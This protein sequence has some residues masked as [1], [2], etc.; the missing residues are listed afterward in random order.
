MQLTWKQQRQFW[1]DLIVLLLGISSLSIATL[2]LKGL[3]AQEYYTALVFIVLVLL[4]SSQA[5]A[6]AGLTTAAC[7]VFYL[8][9]FFV[10]PY[11]NLNVESVTGVLVIGVFLI[12]ATITSQ[13]AARARRQT[14]EALANQRQTLVLNELN[15][16]VLSEA[17]ADTI[18]QRV[19]EQL[20]SSLAA[21]A[22][23]LYLPQ[24]ENNNLLEVSAIFDQTQLF[25]FKL[26]AHIQ[27]VREAF[28]IKSLTGYQLDTCRV[29]C[30]PLLR[31][32]AVLGVV[33]VLLKLDKPYPTYSGLSPE[34]IRWFSIV[35]NQA[36]LTIQHAY[37]IEQSAH[38]A[39]LKE[40]DELKS[41]L[42]ALVSHELR[43]PLTAIKTA[44]AGL[45]DVGVQL[46]PHEQTEYF[47]VIDQES[48]RLIRLISNMLDL[49]SLESGTFKLEKNLY[50]LPEIVTNAIERIKHTPILVSHPL[51]THFEETLP[52]LPVDYLQIEQVLT[53][54][55]ENAA[56]YSPEGMP[57]SV[58]V[59]QA[60]LSVSRFNQSED[61]SEDQSEAKGLLV[62][63][64]DQGVGI[65]VS[66]L[67]KV[68]DKFYR[69]GLRPS[70]ES[71]INRSGS[72]L[73]LALCKGVVEAHGGRIWVSARTH[74]GSI[75]SFW[76]PL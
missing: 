20:A 40:A 17:S 34:A 65:P 3:S 46:E 55:L 10:P 28:S 15:V 1:H 24:P 6:W 59:S 61:Q 27:S 7:G 12:V 66:D 9:F 64:I 22:T 42:L 68:F 44:V 11:Y 53:N 67:D 5:N 31:Q 75:F 60:P 13:I 35:A 47:E 49:T 39:S 50:Y 69:V 32:E 43:T 51:H 73:G 38:L 21:L 33:C 74:G 29:V 4:V 25:D 72:G 71:T 36:A 23:T 26:E 19:V 76:L 18:L 62:A 58:E 8:D 2:I 16:A 37:L 57:I 70:Q 45:K 48:N 56:K 52:L 30:V 54:L 41:T 14:A 63:V